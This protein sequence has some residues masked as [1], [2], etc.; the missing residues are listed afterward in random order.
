[1][2]TQKSNKQDKI[3]FDPFLDIL[4]RFIYYENELLKFTYYIRPR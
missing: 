3:N 1:M 2:I 4:I